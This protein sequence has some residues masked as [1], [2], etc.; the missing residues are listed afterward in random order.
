MNAPKPMVQSRRID[1]DL[2]TA[3]MFLEFEEQPAKGVKGTNRKFSQD[4]VDGYTVEMLE[5]KWY[6]TH[7]GIAFQGYLHDGTAKLVDG[8]QR[9]RALVQAA[10]TGVTVAGVFY[11]P[12]P[13]LTIDVMVTEGVSEQAALVMDIGR[14]RMPGDF[15]RMAGEVNTNA[16][17]STINL[18]ILYDTVPWSRDAWYKY[19][20][21]A[22]D[23]QEYL[24]AHPLLRDAVL[25]G[26]RLT[27]MMT[28]SAAAA[29][30]FLA[31]KS[32]V[33]AEAASDFMDRLLSG[34]DLKDGSPILTFRDLL[35]NARH[36][37]RG[38]F[39]REEQLALFIRVFNKW[40]NGEQSYQLSFKRT[41]AF[42]R[43]TDTD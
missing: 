2:K 17:A 1:L 5:N 7:Q 6:F 27:K 9:T 25:E 41:H 4:V 14:R 20:I 12:R 33:K 3:K 18:A 35:L 16:L 23:R 39:S 34:A 38:K 30:W 10:T 37:R 26:A 32:G 24:E 19:R 40:R 22:A 8:G 15:L 21:T 11:P 28:V 42:P 43:F 36:S 13:D 29:G 31:I